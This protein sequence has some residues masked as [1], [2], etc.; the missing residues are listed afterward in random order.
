MRPTAFIPASGQGLLESAYE[1][2]L[3]YEL[4]KRG[5][6][7]VRQQAVPIVYQGTR[8][9]VGYRA[10]LDLSRFLRQTVKTQNPSNG[11]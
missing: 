2:V 7:T 6:R 1:A 10:D 9:E 11:E 4:E 3:A 5:L 8:I